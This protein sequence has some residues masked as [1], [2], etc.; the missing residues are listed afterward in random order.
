MSITTHYRRLLTLSLLL[1]FSL[2]QA[3][4]GQEENTALGKASRQ[5]ELGDKAL[6]DGY[7]ELA[8]KF[9]RRYRDAA[10]KEKD[11]YAVRDSFLRLISA[12]LADNNPIEARLE[13]DVFRKRF[14][15]DIALNPGLRLLSK[16]WNA[17]I[18]L[19]EGEVDKALFEFEKVIG[20]TEPATELRYQ[21]I[22][23]KATALVR[24][25]K[26]K[27]AAETYGKLRFEA[28]GTRWAEYAAKQE[29][30]A[31]IMSGDLEKAGSL[32]E[33]IYADKKEKDIRHGL[34]QTLFLAR[35]GNIENAQKAY[36]QLRKDGQASDSL[37]F[38]TAY[39]I[40]GEYLENGEHEQSIPLLHDAS[41]YASSS[42]DKQQILL[43]L[44]NSY[45]ETGR[46][47]EAVK[48]C[49][50]F[51]KVFPDCAKSNEV[52]LQLARLLA[53]AG[54]D[55]EAVAAYTE[56]LGNSYL[57][58]S[59]KQKALKELGHLYFSMKQYE[60]STKQFEN[61][62]KLADSP[63]IKGQAEF[64]IAEIIF[65]DKDYEKAIDRFERIASEYKFL[66]EKA[67]LRILKA[68][69]KTGRIAEALK[70]A[71]V[72]L[73]EFPESKSAPEVFFIQARMLYE[74]GRPEEARNAYLEF[75]RRFPE[76]E[77]APRAMLESGNIAFTM[78]DDTAA[79][80]NYAALIG[81]YPE[82]PLAANAL[83]RRVYMNLLC[84][85]EDKA[86]SDMEL[87]KKNFPDS[88]FTVQGIFLIADHWREKDDYDKAVEALDAIARKADPETA[89]QALYEKA[90]VEGL[91]K[92]KDAAVETLDTLGEK[93]PLSPV[94]GHA[95][96]LRGDILT[97]L[98]PLFGEGSDYAKAI[99]F[100]IK[101][102]ESSPG[103]PLEKA[104]WGRLG[105]VYFALDWK[106]PDH[107]NLMKA[108]EYYRRITE[109]DG[110]SADLAHQALYKL[111][112][113]DEEIGDKGSALE[114][115]HE[116]IYSYEILEKSSQSDLVW[117]IKAADN[118]IRLYKEKATPESLESAVGIC[119]QMKSFKTGHAGKYA[120]MIR[121]IRG[122]KKEH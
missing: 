34:I 19:C 92:K 43:L 62:R 122:E 101:A 52:R 77:N 3:L 21:A 17:N 91:A 20:E 113:C 44:I 28:R 119:R 56:L 39:S 110:I 71:E 59:A 24:L 22:S 112:R 9:Y 55:K 53:S 96:F 15:K 80:E 45:A 99:P 87:L 4:A 65:I 7:S 58:E 116:L 47:E 108:V 8:A 106:T 51:L 81:K 42:Y 100:Y 84:G 94:M 1:F 18:F 13:H 16:Y 66:R 27:R 48:T 61:L 85:L 31:L 104:A 10:E 89:P 12:H 103:S 68:L 37:W 86:L 54:R 38:I 79:E 6:E 72:F 2:C 41:V 63:Y 67:L 40:A 115:Y 121:E 32:V 26:W 102:A 64:W 114:K 90:Y 49:E 57:S 75:A 76:D 120:E 50:R 105:D 73:K 97:D 29:V 46:G 70:S 93:Y 11:E 33:K 14:A 60:D 78:G 30:L 74:N 69:Q 35:A 25:L 107:A 82:N 23:G 118:A 109:S 83:H 5:R 88:P 98:N 36:N 95:W 111:A 117:I